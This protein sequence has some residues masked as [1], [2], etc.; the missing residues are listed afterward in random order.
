VPH[1]GWHLRIA[2]IIEAIEAVQDYC[3]GITYESFASDRKTIDAVVRNFIIIGEAATR[4]PEDVTEQHPDL[5]WREMRDM[6]NIAV[7]EY[8]GVDPMIIWQTL[9]RNLPPLLPILK[10]LLISSEK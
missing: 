6:R 9:R 2:D 4:L 5:P 7:H 3:R 8:F 1:R 10:D